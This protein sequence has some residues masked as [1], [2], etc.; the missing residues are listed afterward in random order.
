MPS[1]IPAFGKVWR[2][3]YSL[4]DNNLWSQ[5][6]L[7]SLA[8]VS[9]KHLWNALSQLSCCYASSHV[10]FPYLGK[11]KKK[12][13]KIPMK[14]SRTITIKQETTID[15]KVGFQRKFQSFNA[16]LNT[17]E[18][19]QFISCNC[20]AI[21]PTTL[22]LLKHGQSI[23]QI[24]FHCIFNVCHLCNICTFYSVLIQYFVSK[25]CFFNK[26]HRFLY[27]PN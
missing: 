27:L 13:T 1:A 20:F 26:M 5:I 10:H 21:W 22:T 11:T 7:Q 3:N 15:G 2:T 24:F 12:S 17:D 18:H 8:Q 23:F 16:G 14:H 4:P 19:Y 6:P 9:G 25:F